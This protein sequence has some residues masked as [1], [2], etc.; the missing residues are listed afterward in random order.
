MTFEYGKVMHIVM[1][2]LSKLKMNKN[3]YIPTPRRII[4]NDWANY[5]NEDFFYVF[6]LISCITCG[7]PEVVFEDTDCMCILCA[8]IAAD[9]RI[10]TNEQ[11]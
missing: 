7:N 11:Q 8:D 10:F 9:H 3:K 4:S 5:K 6:H 1:A 2:D